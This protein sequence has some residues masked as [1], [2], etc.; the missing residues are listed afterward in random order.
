MRSLNDRNPTLK[1]LSLNSAASFVNTGSQLPSD[2]TSQPAV[3]GDHALPCAEVN[4][5]SSSNGHLSTS[6]RANDPVH[7]DVEN[8]TTN[9]ETPETFTSASHN[10]GFLILQQPAFDTERPSGPDNQK[11]LIAVQ[12]Q[13]QQHNL[14][15]DSGLDKG[16]AQVA[17]SPI[18]RILESVVD[19]STV[20]DNVMDTLI[21]ADT[22]LILGSVA[23][24][25]HPTSQQLDERMLTTPNTAALHS[26]L[27]VVGLPSENQAT[28]L[29][30]SWKQPSDQDEIMQ[31]VPQSPGKLAR[32]RE[33]DQFDEEPVPKRMRPDKDG[34]PVLEFKVPELPETATGMATPITNVP[35]TAD[36]AITNGH[37]AN[38]I[39]KVGVSKTGLSSPI[40]KP[41]HRFLMRGIQAMK[42]MPIAHSFC[43]P[44]DYES[45]NIPTYPDIVKNP[46]DLKTMEEKLKADKYTTVDSYISDFDQ[47]IQNSILFNGSDHAVTKCA[48]NLKDTFEKQL[49]KLPSS[50]IADLPAPEKKSKKSSAALPKPTP[51]RRESRSSI[52]TAKSPTNLTSPAFALG[53]SGMP[54]IRRDSTATD[55]R[56][57]REIHPPAPRD[58]PYS[59]QKPKKK[60]YQWE[61]KFCQEVLAELRKAKHQAYGWP[62]LNP[63]DPVA[64]NI[65]HYHKL[66]KK[67]MDLSTIE[68]KLKEG[69]YENAK[70]FEMDIRL[71]FANCYKFNPE[72]DTVYGMGKRYEGIFDEKW[73]ERKQ[74]IEDH[75]P[76]SGP[77]SPGSSPEPD[78]DEEEEIEEE[79]ED[80]ELAILQKQIEAMSQQVEMI[81]KKKMSPPAPTKNANKNS[82]P[83][84]KEAK[85]N[86]SSVVVKERKESK[87]AKKGK[88]PYVT[89]EQKQ[90]ISNRINTLPEARMATALS[91][92]RDNMPNLKVIEFANSR[93]LFDLCTNSCKRVY[94]RMK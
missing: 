5:T 12:E 66:I 73:S 56:P 3:N 78:D 15:Y 77:Q 80:N 64:L 84:K 38:S 57:K 23:L 41:Q 36:L 47:M 46:M 62:F 70:E 51:L 67:P 75:A 45:L 83:A 76:A 30:T 82:K 87:T 21:P 60:K 52:G 74:W 44:V 24:P 89:Y 48:L 72:S 31:D 4:G 79:E 17:Q 58:L 59:N 28:Q 91:I 61:L 37:V 33:D 13:T 53:P 16:S 40:T 7:T 94:R 90:D 92:I 81:K 25:H 14:I 34:L 69:E 93:D 50:E 9:P 6:E 63:V 54:L 88:S 42:R 43:L 32:S 2:A 49:S 18:E 71:M 55:G 65:P 1:D 85:K 27:E 86:N 20:Q 22:E 26:V 19:T 11:H 10:S 39:V 8:A 29:P 35:I 68:K